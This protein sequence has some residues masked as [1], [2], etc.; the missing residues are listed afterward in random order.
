MKKLSI[1]TTVLDAAMALRR[2]NT[3]RGA[4]LLGAAALSTKAPG[5]GTFASVAVRVYQRLR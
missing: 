3:R 1:A 2:G 5:L 4:A